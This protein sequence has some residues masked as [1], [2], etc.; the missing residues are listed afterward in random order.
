MAMASGFMRP[1]QE[2]VD[3]K[4]K[5]WHLVQAC[6]RG[7][8]LA[9]RPDEQATACRLEMYG[10]QYMCHLGL[11]PCTQRITRV[12]TEECLCRP[13]LS[14]VG[15][16]AT[17]IRQNI[18]SIMCW[19]RRQ[20][21]DGQ[22][23]WNWNW[24][25]VAGCTREMDTS[26]LC[27]KST[28]VSLAGQMGQ[29]PQF[30]EIARSLHEHCA[31]QAWNA[32]LHAAHAVMQQQAAAAA[33][34]R[35]ITFFSLLHHFSTSSTN[36]PRRAILCTYLLTTSISEVLLSI[37]RIRGWPTTTAPPHMACRDDTQPFPIWPIQGPSNSTST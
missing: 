10:L 13:G 35:A 1:S 27:F 34:A 23:D 4:T 28:H 25:V 26:S 3:A 20:P 14:T 15:E 9:A 21:G 22:C 29:V 16:H 12:C 36:G 17:S 2:V 18:Q 32:A 11:H 8:L 19:T 33:A 5:V 30:E 24:I 37:P 6:R 31:H 7:P